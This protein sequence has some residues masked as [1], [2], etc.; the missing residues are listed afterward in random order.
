MF[1]KVDDDLIIN[2]DQIRY[3]VEHPGG[4]EVN[5]IYFE[6]ADKALENADYIDLEDD[7]FGRFY[8]CLAIVVA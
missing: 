1:I 5:R 6:A 2:T 7:S 8:S 3:I 4:V